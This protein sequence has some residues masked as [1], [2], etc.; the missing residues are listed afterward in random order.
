MRTLFGGGLTLI[1]INRLHAQEMF[2]LLSDA[3]IYEFIDGEPPS[4]IEQLAEKYSQ[5][6]SGLSPDATAQWLNW[7]VSVPDTGLVGSVQASVYPDHGAEV[8]FV[9]GTAFWGCGY[10]SAA[11]EAMLKELA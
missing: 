3:T 2:E 8:G 9:F 7:V 1:P 4:S 5:L 10:A 11:M 6:E